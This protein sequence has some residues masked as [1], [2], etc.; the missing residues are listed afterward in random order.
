MKEEGVATFSLC[1]D[2]GS[3]GNERGPALLPSFEPNS[4]R[5]G[6]SRFG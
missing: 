5:S 6:H 4:R 3:S 2:A 1:T